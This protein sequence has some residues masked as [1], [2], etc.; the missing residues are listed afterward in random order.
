VAAAAA[1]TEPQLRRGCDLAHA[2]SS[3]FSHRVVA[4]NAS[5]V[6]AR[7]VERQ[8][9]KPK[10][11]RLNVAGSRPVSR[12]SSP[13]STKLLSELEDLGRTSRRPVVS[14]RYEDASVA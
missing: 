8:P 4:T 13:L 9:S 6:L 7:P 12:S 3:L 2:A 14:A 11:Y 10:P 1:T 5:R